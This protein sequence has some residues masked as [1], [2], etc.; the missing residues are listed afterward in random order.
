MYIKGRNPSNILWVVVCF[1]LTVFVSGSLGSASNIRAQSQK[2]AKADPDTPL[3]QEYKGVSLGMKTDEARKK[4]GT[5]TEKDDE[6][7]FFIVSDTESAQI[8]YDKAHTV[9]AVSVNYIGEGNG[10]PKP[11]DILGT[12][13]VA[14]PDG[15]MHQLIRYPKEG[16]WVSYSRTA[17]AS[18]VITIT[19]KKL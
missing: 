12:D 17:G 4:L 5:P 1:V 6:Q 3:F 15:S 14:K 13:V 10:V 18:P 8:Y 11:K 2:K 7:D 9:M 16:L 19:V